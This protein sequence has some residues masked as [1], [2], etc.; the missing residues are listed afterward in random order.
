MDIGTSA[1]E[2]D[3]RWRPP[4]HLPALWPAIQEH[5]SRRL[6]LVFGNEAH[7]LNRDE[8]AQCHILLHLDTWG[9]YSSYNLASAVAIIG[10]HIAAH[11]HQQT[12]A[13]HPTPTHKQPADIALVERL[14]SYWLD[15]LERC[16]YFRGNRRRDIYEPHFRQLLQRLA[17]SK[18]DATTLFASLAQFNYYSFGDKHLND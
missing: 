16:A 5:G 2:R 6:A 4:V 8:L 13:S 1:R 7:G 3:E 18:E 17:L 10:H 14:G 9:D 12:T 15:S 11:I